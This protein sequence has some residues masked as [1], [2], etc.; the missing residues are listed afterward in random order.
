M[1]TRIADL[2]FGP[3]GDWL[4]GHPGRCF[5]L[6]L[7]GEELTITVWHAA[8]ACGIATGPAETFGSM[9]ARAINQCEH[10]LRV[11]EEMRSLREDAQ[12]RIA[13]RDGRAAE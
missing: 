3:M 8:T 13:A 12:R 4:A 11:E 2:D 6:R 10:N 5:N 7:F 1:R 9:I